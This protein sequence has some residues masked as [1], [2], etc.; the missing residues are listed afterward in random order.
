MEKGGHQIRLDRRR[1][2]PQQA[3]NILK[4][5]GTVATIEEAKIILDFMY[6]I[7]KLSVETYIKL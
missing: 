3:V 4:E 5:H 7:A 6:K 2:T 1:I